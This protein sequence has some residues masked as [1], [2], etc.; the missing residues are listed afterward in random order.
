MDDLQCLM[1]G[2]DDGVLAGVL[3]RMFNDCNIEVIESIPG[4]DSTVSVTNDKFSC[5]IVGKG[6]TQFPEVYKNIFKQYQQ[7]IVVEIL[8]DG[9]SVRLLMDDVSSEELI[10]LIKASR[11]INIS[12]ESL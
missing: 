5:L 11:K 12:D 9:K 2:V 1:C 10:N 7:L 3:K 4:S 6:K 8:N